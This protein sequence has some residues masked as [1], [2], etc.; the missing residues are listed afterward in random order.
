MNFADIASCLERALA[1]AEGMREADYKVLGVNTEHHN[2]ELL[3][4]FHLR[5]LEA[6]R[7]LAE[8]SDLNFSNHN[9]NLHVTAVVGPVKLL[10]I[11]V[12][13]TTQDVLALL[14][15]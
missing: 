1:L 13:T 8:D 15:D 11:K 4:K 14:E 9:G 3:V 12:D 10:W 2:G 6:F 7:E 5:D